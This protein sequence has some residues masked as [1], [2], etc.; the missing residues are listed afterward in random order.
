MNTE[1]GVNLVHARFTV[2]RGKVAKVHRKLINMAL[3]HKVKVMK[4]FIT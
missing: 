2:M 3:D 1:L 4:S